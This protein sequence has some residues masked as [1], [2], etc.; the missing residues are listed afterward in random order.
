MY[1]FFKFWNKSKKAIGQ[2]FAE[3][4][5][6]LAFV[7]VSAMLAVTILEPSLGGVFSR[8]VG[9]EEIAPPALKNYQ[10]PPTA[11]LDPNYTPEPTSTIDPAVT[12]TSTPNGYEPGTAT[13]TPSPSPT[14]T[15]TPAP[16]P[17]ICNTYTSSD[18]PSAC[19]M[20]QIL[21]HLISWPG[22]GMGQSMTSMSQ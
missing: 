2:G 22:Q 17:Q 15:N 12:A 1:I 5:L 20:A 18:T 13:S 3:Y 21:L 16:L 6:I 4:A 9:K 7:G 10:A 8:L 14:S 19:Q 11:T